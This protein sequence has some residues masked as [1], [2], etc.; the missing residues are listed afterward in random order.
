MSK[1]TILI[2]PEEE[3]EGSYGHTTLVTKEGIVTLNQ[4]VDLYTYAT[5]GAG[6]YVDKIGAVVNE[7]IEFWGEH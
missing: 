2:E 3:H 5:S 1:V 7:N 4:L 6:W